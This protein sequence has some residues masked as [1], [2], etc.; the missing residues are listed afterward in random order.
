MGEVVWINGAFGA[1]KTSVARGLRR[2]IPRS[3]VVDPELIG[4][5]VL[6]LPGRH[7][8]DFQRSPLWRWATVTAVRAAALFGPVIVPMTVVEDDVLDDV[9]GSLQRKG[10]D[11]RMVALVVGEEELRTR[12]R[13]RGSE[14]R[15]GEAQI[16]RC[17]QAVGT[18]R[19]GE[20][21]SAEGR[22]I[23]AVTDAVL[24]AVGA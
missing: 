23:E 10:G 18:P 21:I 11:V 9:V 17:I 13:R 20:P 16:Q 8:A 5:V 14:G 19:F 4:F 6:R 22:P 1:G 24:A 7:R 2:R 12:L 15:W 3:R